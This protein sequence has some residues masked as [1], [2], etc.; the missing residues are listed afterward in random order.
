MT[1][2]SANKN[3]QPSPFHINAEYTLEEIDQKMDH[4][5]NSISSELTRLKSHLHVL[6]Q[7]PTHS[8]QFE[9]QELME[10]Y[11]DDFVYEY[12]KCKELFKHGREI[13]IHKEL[14]E[15]EL[16]NQKRFARN[17]LLQHGIHS[18]HALEEFL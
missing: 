13:R 9:E 5:T 15:Q 3:T 8:T 10:E 18:Y 14:K 2:T 16:H 12:T 4:V 1:Q 17:V 11:I 7:L 6:S